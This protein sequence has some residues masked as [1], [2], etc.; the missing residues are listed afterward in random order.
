MGPTYRQTWRA[1]IVGSNGATDVSR[2]VIDLLFEAFMVGFAW[3][4]VE[5]KEL[6]NGNRM[7]LA[8]RA[9]VVRAVATITRERLMVTPFHFLFLQIDLT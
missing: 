2:S 6:R 7:P 3:I 8:D 9:V 4:S 1:L 5:H